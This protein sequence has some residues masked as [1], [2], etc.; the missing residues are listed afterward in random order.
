[1]SYNTGI[2]MHISPNDIPLEEALAKVY[3]VKSIG[4]H[5]QYVRLPKCLFAKRV[6]ILLV[7]E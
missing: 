6:K 5:S 2:E 3:L 7:E 4:P 1:M